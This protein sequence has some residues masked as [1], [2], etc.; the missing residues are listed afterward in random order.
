MDTPLSTFSLTQVLQGKLGYTA[1]NSIPELSPLSELGLTILT[2]R[3]ARSL[4]VVAIWESDEPLRTPLLEVE[5]LAQDCAAAI[6]GS[7]STVMVRLM[8]AEP[9]ALNLEDVER[10]RAAGFVTLG[11]P[12]AV[13]VWLIDP[14]SGATY[15]NESSVLKGDLAPL[16]AVFSR[17]AELS[18]KVDLPAPRRPAYFSYAL[19]FIIGA[20]YAAELYLVPGASLLDGPPPGSLLALGGSSSH[21]LKLGEFWRLTTAPLLHLNFSHVL[22]NGIALLLIGPLL[23][24]WIGTRWTASIFVVSAAIGSLASAIFHDPR[25]VGVGASGGLY[26]LFAASLIVALRLPPGRDRAALLRRAASILALSVLPLFPGGSEGAAIDYV[27]HVGGAIAGT[28]A[29]A[30]LIF[31]YSRDSAARSLKV[32]TL[33][34][35]LAF[36][37]VAVASM[38]PISGWLPDSRLVDPA[39]QPTEAAWRDDIDQKA[40]EFPR[41]PRLKYLLAGLAEEAGQTD[42]ALSLV[43]EGLQEERLLRFYLPDLRQGLIVAKA[44]LVLAKGRRQEAVEIARPACVEATNT[45]VRQMLAAKNLCVRRP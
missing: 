36:F 31:V 6:A 8:K 35:P 24:R 37:A 28:L 10:L 17:R 12:R 44:S 21:V 30:T 38:L 7:A 14:V 27:A 29:C 33:V 4:H 9:G 40:R 25:V 5:A 1:D 23:E 13:A 41:D 22:L 42:R 43:E 34:L 15:S 16:D 20:V 32:A 18:A 39:W 19:F 11:K 3:D 26:G 45:K 2:K